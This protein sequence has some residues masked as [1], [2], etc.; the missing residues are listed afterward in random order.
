MVANVTTRS[1]R[2][3]ERGQKSKDWSSSTVDARIAIKGDTLII[4]YDRPVEG[5]I[6]RGKIV[7][8]LKKDDE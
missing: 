2:R 1:C 8:R 4:Q 5:Y 3:R 6:A 7:L